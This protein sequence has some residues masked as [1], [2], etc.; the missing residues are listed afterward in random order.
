MN[1][2]ERISG[3]KALLESHKS[4]SFHL[5]EADGSYRLWRDLSAEGRLEKIVWDAAYFDVPF[6]Q[7]AE[8]VRESVDSAAIGD[9]ALRLAMRSGRELHH[10]ER[11]FPDNGQTG[12]APLVERV[13]ELLDAEYFAHESDEML[14]CG[15]LAALF[16][17]MR[18]DYAAARREDAHQYGSGTIVDEKT[19]AS[20]T[21]K[22]KDKEIER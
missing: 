2:K 3:F 11:L 18:A 13:R 7:F 10:L 4:N 1:V 20:A 22:N 6:E 12:P 17:E 9:A 16:E 8:A 19:I 5:A 15:K 14:T 21:E